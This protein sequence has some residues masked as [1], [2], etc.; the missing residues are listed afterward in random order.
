MASAVA[1]RREGL[2]F[3]QVTHS[4]KSLCLR[5][6]SPGTP[7]SSHS[8]MACVLGKLMTLIVRRCERDCE[9]LFELSTCDWITHD[10]F[11]KPGGNWASIN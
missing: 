4:V 11:L 1:S 7:A 10:R 6:V 2:G 8:P 5:E 9:H 3:T